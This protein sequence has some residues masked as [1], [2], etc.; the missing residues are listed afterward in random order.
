M[1]N[2]H[3]ALI[4]RFLQV[5]RYDNSKQFNKCLGGICFPSSWCKSRKA[6]AW[7]IDPETAGNVYETGKERVELLQTPAKTVYENKEG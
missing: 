7:K 3:N 5:I 4:A 2:E 6:T 1:C